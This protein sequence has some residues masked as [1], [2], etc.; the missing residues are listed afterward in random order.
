Q[1]QW[2]NNGSNLHKVWD[3]H[4]IDDYGMSYSELAS[5]LPAIDRQRRKELQQGTI[6]DWAEESQELADKVYSSVE[7]GQ[8]LYYRYGYKWWGTVE[9]QLQKGGLRLAK[10]L[11]EVFK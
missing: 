3:T 2:F 11:N 4:M 7:V 1:L 9:M 6:L 10:V 5:K 8:K